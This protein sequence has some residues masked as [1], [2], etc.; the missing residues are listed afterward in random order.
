PA[1]RDTEVTLLRAQVEMLQRRLSEIDCG[2]A[3]L[4]ERTLSPAAREARRKTAANSTDPCRLNSDA[5]L[6]LST[7]P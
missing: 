3:K 4:D 5:P 6:R 2:L 7:R 1:A